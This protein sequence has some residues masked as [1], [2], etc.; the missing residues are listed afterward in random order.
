MAL[1]SVD[2]GGL[3]NAQIDVQQEQ[4]LADLRINQVQIPKQPVDP[5]LEQR[6]VAQVANQW[7]QLDQAQKG[8][9]SLW[10]K[11]DLGK[12]GSFQRGQARPETDEP[13]L[14]RAAITIDG[15]RGGGKKTTVAD[16]AQAQARARAALR[17]SAGNDTP[18]WRSIV[19]VHQRAAE[20]EEAHLDRPSYGAATGGARS[21]DR[22]GRYRRRVLLED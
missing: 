16:V 12:W 17:H 2:A 22:S 10:Q 6:G 18:A 4:Q 19:A 9:G 14:S 15:D 5:M 20:F 11:G 21:S 7:A 13:E 1:R 3:G 8:R